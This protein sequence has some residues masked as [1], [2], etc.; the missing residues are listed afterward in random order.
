MECPKD[1]EAQRREYHGLGCISWNGTGKLVRI[2]GTM[3]QFVYCSILEEGLVPSL[4]DQGLQAA[5]IIFQQDNN[6]KP[7]QNTLLDSPGNGTL[8]VLSL[9]Y[10]SFASV[11]RC[12]YKILNV[13]CYLE[14]LQSFKLYLQKEQIS[15]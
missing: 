13:L 15:T 5:D 6:P 7:T 10:C 9:L 8:Q 12:I 3:N 4:H 14:Y 11:W 2:E 1:D